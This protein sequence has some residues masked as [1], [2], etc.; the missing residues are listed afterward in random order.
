M[1]PAVLAAF[2]TREHYL[3]MEHPGRLL[4]R[5]R[6]LLKAV[7]LRW[8]SPIEATYRRE[9][10]WDESARFPIQLLDYGLRSWGFL[11]R[12]PSY[13]RDLLRGR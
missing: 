13:L 11:A 2:G 12:T 9:A 10:P 5:P 6:T 3:H 4:T 1:T 8:A 7:R